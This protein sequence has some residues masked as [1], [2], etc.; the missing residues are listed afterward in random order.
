VG[1]GP[2]RVRVDVYRRF[3]SHS[4]KQEDRIL[5]I[6]RGRGDEH[7]LSVVQFNV[8]SGRALRTTYI[9]MRNACYKCVNLSVRDRERGLQE[10][11]SNFRQKG[12]AWREEDKGEGEDEEIAHVHVNS[13]CSTAL[14]TR[15]NAPIFSEI[16]KG[17]TF[18]LDKVVLIMTISKEVTVQV[19]TVRSMCAIG[20]DNIVDMNE[21]LSYCPKL[22]SVLQRIAQYGRAV[23][24][25]V[26]PSGQRSRVLKRGDYQQ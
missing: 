20:R 13:K 11:I 26:T 18:M 21:V 15:R 9:Q 14:H 16:N 6:I 3:L 5:F 1:T 4:S 2:A 12:R 22:Q 10:V 25:R 17:I 19:I 24:V 8:A 7:E 23:V